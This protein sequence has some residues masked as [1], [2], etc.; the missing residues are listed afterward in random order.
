MS[1][2]DGG[3]A[4][5]PT[6]RPGRGRPKPGLTDLLQYHVGRPELLQLDAAL[7]TQY[8]F[9]KPPRGKVTLTP[10]L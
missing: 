8:L 3:H 1:E 5:L 10:E 9:P 2:E 6:Q 7:A 4:A